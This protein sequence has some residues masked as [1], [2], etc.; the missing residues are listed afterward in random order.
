M[1]NLLSLLLCL[2]IGS[3]AFAQGKIAGAVTDGSSAETLI[4]VSIS[5]FEKG[6][7]VPKS[8]TLTDID[9]NFSF[10][11]EAG[12]YEVE[13]KYVGYQAKKITDIVVTDNKTTKVAV[14]MDERK[15][16]ELD[17]V[18]IQGT[19]KKESVNALYTMQKNAVAV[20]DGIS[21]DVIKRSPDRSTGEA[22]KRVSGTTIQDNK[23]V[24][25]RGLSDRYNSALVDDAMMPSTE[26]N[27]KAFSFDIIPASMID[28]IIITKSGTPDLP[29]DFAGGVINILTKEVPDEN[30]TN[31]S[32]GTGYNT[33]STGKTFQSGYR[34]PT[35]FLGFDNGER[36]LHPNFPTTA[37][38]NK[39]NP[40][41]PQQ[42]VP[43]LKALNNDFSV[44]E[45]KALPAASLQ[46][47][48]GRV[49]H[50]K[51]NSRFGVTAAVTY[52]HSENIK[53]DLKREYDNY[54]YNDNIYNYSSNLGALLNLG[55]YKGKS[56]IN[57]KTFYNR[58]F[59]DN[60]LYREGENYSSTKD[61]KYYAFDLIQKSL[62]KTTLNGEH[63]V[64]QGQSKLSWLVS[65]NYITNNQ[66]DQRKVSYFES[67][68]PGQY[69]ADVTTLGRANNRLFGDMNESV[70]NGGVN[71][72]LPFKF[73]KKSNLKIGAFGQYRYRDFENRYLGAVINTQKPDYESVISR[74]I[75]TLFGNDVI[76]NNYYNITDLTGDADRY[77]ATATNL[78][79]YVMMDNKITE[80]FR[81]VYGARLESYHV[82]LNTLTKNEVD[83]T[84]TDIL[85][86]V[87]LTYSLNDKS[88]LRASYFRSVARPELREMA[89]L[90]YY[91][92]E[93][94]ANITGN[95]SLERTGINNF[96]LRY[97]WFLG[98][99]EILSASAFYKSFTNTLEN[100]L[101]GAGSAYDI[102]TVN[103]KKATNIGIEIELRKKL[104]FIAEN[105]F[106]K[107]MSYYMNLAYIHSAVD[108]EGYVRGKF[109]EKRPLSGQAPIVI[110]TS[111]GYSS[112]N[113]MWNVNLL[114][115]RVGQR[116]TYVG[117][118]RFGHVY[119]TPRNLLDFQISCAITKHSEFRLNIKDILNNPVRYYFDQNMDE[120]FNGSAFHE[121]K[122]F[123]GE[124]W[125]MQEFKPGSTFSLTYSYKF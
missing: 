26:P 39:L 101:Y 88:N 76:T 11:A 57:L 60:F 52:N 72:S 80:N 21:S 27:R 122:I 75:E 83:R 82:S 35:D 5:L 4:G 62:F 66:P 100:R 68:T 53:K 55:Y 120:K 25:V 9:G 8:G 102:R 86:S 50:L 125:I 84:W 34:T 117:D 111:L 15:N 31:F 95:T 7:E 29:G 6:E 79:G 46:A 3:Q 64:G 12:T 45:H 43:Y 24:I 63:Q 61:I 44:N 18:V 13:I 92:Y 124:D 112:E 105:S 87:N 89:N 103:F 77:D 74:P 41:K 58:I 32:I 91:D 94:N 2:L 37:G 56:K 97:E 51:G 69:V 85:P 96:D 42:S 49:F 20:S 90:A 107:N 113:G 110:N 33:A 59:D 78:G 98:Q 81:A 14:T 16:T 119:E 109:I 1:R 48:L 23:F 36:Q 108:H 93:L 121:G 10:E 104:G 116:L 118:D 54:D 38:I 70:L 67:N 28:N 71:Y 106:L 47:S 123:E 65:Y 115:N 73:L 19:L 17:E 114:Y 99:G 40:N 22:L 30:F